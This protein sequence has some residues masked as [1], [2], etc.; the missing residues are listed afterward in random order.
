MKKQIGGTFEIGD[1]DIQA[2]HDIPQ[3]TYFA[4]SPLYRNIPI[5]KT[6]HPPDGNVL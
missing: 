6:G 3:K 5:K 2:F 1:I 4:L